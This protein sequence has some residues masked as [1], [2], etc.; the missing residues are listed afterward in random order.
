MSKFDHV[1]PTIEESKDL[2]TCTFV[3]MM[4]SLLAHI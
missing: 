3:E 1:V 2:S 4:T